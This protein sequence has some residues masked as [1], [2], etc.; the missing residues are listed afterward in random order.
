MATDPFDEPTLSVEDIVNIRLAISANLL[1]IRRYQEVLAVDAINPKATYTVDGEN[2]QR[3]EWREGIGRLKEALIKEN[4]LLQGMIRYKRSIDW[5][6]KPES[7]QLDYEAR[8]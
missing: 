3:N 2:V 5:L 1:A 7:E 8:N 6:G 4:L